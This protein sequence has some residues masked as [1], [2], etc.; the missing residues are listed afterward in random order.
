VSAFAID[1]DHRRAQNMSEVARQVADH[2]AA[3][4]PDE[5][6]L[7]VVGDCSILV[8]ALAGYERRVDRLGLVYLD[9]H[10]DLNT[11]QTWPRPCASPTAC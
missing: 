4:V 10:P 3:S 6:P 9:A 1:R 11:P 5:L 8:G 7:I 2:V